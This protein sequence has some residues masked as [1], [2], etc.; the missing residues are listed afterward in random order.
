MSWA[1]LRPPPVYGPGDKEMLPLFRWMYRGIAPVLGPTDGRFSMLYVEDLAEAV[2][3]WLACG[4][5]RQGVFELHDG[6]PDGYRWNDLTNTMARLRGGRVRQV[7]VSARLLALLAV[8]NFMAARVAG[9][10]PMLTPGKVRELRHP[11]WV[12]DNT[13]LS[14]ETGWE[15]AGY[16][17]VGVALAAAGLREWAKHDDQRS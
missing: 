17:L 4:S 14:R 16:V 2:V 3:Q 13:S 9:Y 12:C 8:I 15:T 10:S 5:T 1:V 7:R 6:Q 11:N